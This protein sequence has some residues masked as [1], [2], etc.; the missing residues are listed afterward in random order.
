MFDDEHAQYQ[1]LIVGWRESK[2]IFFP[3]FHVS[4]Q[5]GK[6]WVH[7]HLSDYDLVGEL[8]VNQVPPQGIVLAF[9]APNLRKYTS[10]A[11]E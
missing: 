2:R 8:E 5:N 10:Y 7:Q 3:V 1:V 4:V 6:I 11:I 9:H